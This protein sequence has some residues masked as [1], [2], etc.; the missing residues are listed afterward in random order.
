MNHPDVLDRVEVGRV[1]RV[2]DEECATTLDSSNDAILSVVAE[3]TMT[4]SIVQHDDTARP[5]EGVQLW[6][7]YLFKEL[8]DIE[9]GERTTWNHSVSNETN[10]TLS[11]WLEH[12]AKLHDT[13]CADDTSVCGQHLKERR[14]WVTA[15]K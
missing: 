13:K 3:S 14:E 6:R 11:V 4:W 15:A 12:W 1:W 2:P 5:R 9:C 7:Q 10:I 8:N